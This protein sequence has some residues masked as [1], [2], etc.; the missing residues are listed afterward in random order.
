[1][2][3]D[4]HFPSGLQQWQPRLESSGILQCGPPLR[5]ESEA[6]SQRT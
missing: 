1:P 2:R 3:S 6:R 5:T 4:I